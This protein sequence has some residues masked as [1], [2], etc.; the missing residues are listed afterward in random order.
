MAPRPG[1]RRALLRASAAVAASS[2][3]PRVRAQQVEIQGFRFEP[4]ERVG[5]TE[6]L[7]NGVG[8]RRRLFIPVYVAALYVPQRSS[9][10]EELLVQ[11]G[12]RR[13]DLRFV[14]D[15]EA[16]LFMTSLAAGMAKHYAPEQLERWRTQIDALN[17]VIR[18]M[19]LARRGDRISWDY[20]PPEGCRV[21]QNSIARIPSLAGEDFYNA[22]LRVWLGEF[23]ADTDLK[24]G[25]LGV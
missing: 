18:T 5:G 22:V 25:L 11:R 14:R 4:T 23:P 21:V 6:L 17:T 7:L 16:E 9:D 15:V 20:T 19:V 8:V 24:R 2:L 1:G 10:P 3:L 13:M 12:P